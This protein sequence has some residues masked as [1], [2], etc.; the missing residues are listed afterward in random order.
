MRNK[1]NFS[2]KGCYND[3][4]QILK[5]SWPHISLPAHCPPTFLLI[6]RAKHINRQISKASGLPLRPVS[7]LSHHLFIDLHASAFLVFC[8]A[9]HPPQGHS[10]L[11]HAN[12]PPTFLSVP[13]L[14]AQSMELAIIY[15]PNPTTCPLKQ[16]LPLD[17]RNLLHWPLLDSFF[18]FLTK[19]F[20]AQSSF[21]FSTYLLCPNILIQCFLSTFCMLGFSFF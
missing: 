16:F 3:V 2:E 5:L 12:T 13:H 21:L 4:V 18:L 19:S 7:S 1:P 10:Q 20:R 8:C 11:L 17:F 15:P 14:G 9:G 6:F